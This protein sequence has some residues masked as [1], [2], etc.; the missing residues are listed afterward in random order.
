[1]VEKETGRSRGFG[2]VSYDNSASAEA[3]IQRMNGY[4]VHVRLPFRVLVP[5]FEMWCTVD[6]SQTLEGAAQEG[7]RRQPACARQR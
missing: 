1:M 5:R 6:W 2:F 4:Q 3:A 7:E